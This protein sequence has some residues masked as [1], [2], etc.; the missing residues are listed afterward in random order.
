M[1][2]PL[3]QTISLYDLSLAVITKKRSGVPTAP[4]ATAG[5]APVPRGTGVII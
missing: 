5:G 3:H 4:P 2:P 1:G